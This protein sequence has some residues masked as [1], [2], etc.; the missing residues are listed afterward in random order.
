VIL[1][2]YVGL[3]SDSFVVRLMPFQDSD[4]NKIYII[5]KM[6]DNI[7]M[8]REDV[9]KAIKRAN[10]AFEMADQARAMA[11]QMVALQGLEPRIARAE[12]RLK[13]LEDSSTT[14]SGGR[15]TRRKRL[16]K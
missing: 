7:S 13:R 14:T 4:K 8:L 6:A 1:L 3:S 10:D 5:R 2:L 12:I 16:H 9:N 11:V 15:S